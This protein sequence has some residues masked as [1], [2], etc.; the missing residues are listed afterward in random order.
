MPRMVSNPGEL[1]D[2][3]RHPLQ[4]P[5]VGVEPVGL[6]ALEQGLLDAGQVGRRQLGIGPGRTSTA[7]GIHP[8]LFEAGVPEMGALARDAEGAGDLGLAV[9]LGEQLGCLEPSG[10]QSGTLLSG[11]RMAGIAGRSHTTRSAVNP[12]HEPQYYEN[13]GP[14]VL[15]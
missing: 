13:A 6:G 1:R 11:R 8:A 7:Q 3:H 15:A 10:L 12:T 14:W 9:A 5:Q 2:H 4:G